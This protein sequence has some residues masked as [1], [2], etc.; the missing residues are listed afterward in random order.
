MEAL[1]FDQPAL[2]FIAE[3][4]TELAGFD[5]AAISVVRDGLLHTV[6]VAG[7]EGA[8]EQLFA[9]P[10]PVE[11][12]MAE[13]ANGEDW[14]R[15]R[16][17]PHEREGPHLVGYSWIPDLEVRDVPDAWH[18][19]DLLCGLLYDAEGSLR[20]MLSIDR[21]RNGRRPGPE[22]QRILQVYVRQAERAVITALER[23]DFARDL[24]RERAVAEYRAQLMDVL[25]HE[26]QNPL[27][28]IRHNAELLLTEDDLAPDTVRGLEAILRGAHRIQVM[29]EDLLVLARVG[30]PDRP[31]DDVVDLAVVVRD[32]V[33]VGGF[34]DVRLDVSVDLTMEAGRSRPESGN[35]L[36]VLGDRADLDALVSNLLSNAAK[37]SEPGGHVS[38]TVRR[39]E[40]PQGPRAELVVEDDG[41]GIDAADRERVFEE[42][43]RSSDP[44]VRARPG[45]GLGLAIVDRVVTR[46]GGSVS[47]DSELGHGTTVRVLL[48]L[49]DE[50]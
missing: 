26:V 3:A 42:F 34:A 38:V 28:A 17:V 4:V 12:V 24:E 49:A 40:T 15:L 20:G 50:P 18:P 45:T 9:K 13:L 39:A 36:D 6:A 41:V 11:L 21:P 29:G 35:A 5:V 32:V 37:Y 2:Q 7:D 8:R 44:R 14:G 48:P 25:S 33:E 30:V 19:H 1:G 16:F 23:D 47:V 46:H 27:T 43:Y 31:L 22:Q 10:S